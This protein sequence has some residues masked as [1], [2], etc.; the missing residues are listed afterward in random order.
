MF[1]WSKHLSEPSRG[2]CRPKAVLISTSVKLA[3]NVR[4]A[5]NRVMGIHADPLLTSPKFADS[6]LKRMMQVADILFR[7]YING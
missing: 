7:T 4:V 2:R 1:R 3:T 5:Q 6:R